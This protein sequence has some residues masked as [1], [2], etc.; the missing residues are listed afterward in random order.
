MVAKSLL[1]LYLLGTHSE[2]NCGDG[3]VEVTFIKGAGSD[4]ASPASSSEGVLQDAR[5]FGVSVGDMFG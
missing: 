1:V 2:L 5:E 4:D 3:L